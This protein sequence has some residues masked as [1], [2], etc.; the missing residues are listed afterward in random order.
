MKAELSW[1]TLLILLGTAL[2]LGIGFYLV[3]TFLGK[4]P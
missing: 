2:V 4:L 1:E 3:N